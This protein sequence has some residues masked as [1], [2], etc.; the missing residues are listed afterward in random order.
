MTETPQTPTP[1][2]T[3]TADVPRRTFLLPPSDPLIFPAPLIDGL[4]RLHD[5]GQATGLERSEY[6][7]S[8]RVSIPIPI[9]RSLEGRPGWKHVNPL[10]MWH[11]LMWLPPRVAGTYE[12][13]SVDQWAARVALEC[14]AAGMYVPATG[15]WTDVLALVGIDTRTAE[16]RD[17]VVAWLD[18]HPDEILDTL[19]LSEVFDLPGDPDWAVRAIADVS[20]RLDKA[21]YFLMA[22]DV[23]NIVEDFGEPDSFTDDEFPA[24]RRVLNQTFRMAAHWLADM[25]VE[26]HHTEFEFS[27][28]AQNCL[29]WDNPSVEQFFD[30]VVSPPAYLSEKIVT[31][32][33]PDYE[34]MVEYLSGQGIEGTPAPQR[35]DSRTHDSASVAPDA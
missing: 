9:R 34:F 14:I 10:M 21:S 32:C 12:G 16:G 18:G 4:D 23:L 28:A 1:A 13:E 26:D 8:Q 11:P 6:V 3:T 7:V 19:D 27:Q 24:V 29:D 22:T 25:H 30:E 2:M 20:D 17:R 31:E 35:S 33:Q 15:E 5:F